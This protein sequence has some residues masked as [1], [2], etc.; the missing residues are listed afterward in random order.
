[1]DYL[2]LNN[3]SI[4]LNKTGQILRPKEYEH[5][6]NETDAI[7]ICFDESQQDYFFKYS[8]EQ[9]YLSDI[10]LSVSVVCLVFHI[11]VHCAIPKLRNLPGKNLLSLSCALLLAQF[12][13]LAVI[14][15]RES[16]G[17]ALCL[18]L[19]ALSHWSYLA[20]FFWMNI[21]GVDVSRTFV[22]PQILVRHNSDGRGQRSTYRFYSLYAWGLPTLIVSTGLLVDLAHLSERYGPNYGDHLCWICNKRGLAVFFIVPVASVL[23]ANSILFTLTICSIIRQ[24]KAAKFAVQGTETYREAVVT[25]RATS[26]ST[27][28]L[29]AIRTSLVRKCYSTEAKHKQQ[30]RFVL[31]LKLALI[32][33]LGWISGFVA[34]LTEL[35]VLW[36]PF[37]IFN[38]LQGAF[39]FATFTCKRKIYYMLYQRIMGRPHPLDR[40]SSTMNGRTR[41]TKMSTT[42]QPAVAVSQL[43]DQNDSLVVANVKVE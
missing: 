12:L 16:V 18:S 4:V 13:F 19:G 2:S 6:P 23:V 24:K 1:M 40:S 20:A 22:G 39:I 31:Y 37:I 25:H 27:A 42:S 28:K 29:D 7:Q 9:R 35:T 15:A 21:M 26:Q 32:M 38:A 5:H 43:L 17:H 8:T 3:G 14:D 10:C 33:G 36:Y 11:L 41:T 34:A 30:I